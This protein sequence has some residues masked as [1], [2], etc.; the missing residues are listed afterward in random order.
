VSIARIA[1]SLS[2]DSL[3]VYQFPAPAATI[4]LNPGQGL[5]GGAFLD[6]HGRKRRPGAHGKPRARYLTITMLDDSIPA[7]VDSLQK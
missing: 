5:Q 6:P 2:P 4:I 1:L 3:E 7:G